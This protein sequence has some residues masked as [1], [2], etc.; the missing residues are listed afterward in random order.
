[1]KRTVETLYRIGLFASI[2]MIAGMDRS[3]LAQRPE[4]PK[5]EAPPKGVVLTGAAALALTG[6]FFYSPAPRP[7]EIWQPSAGDVA[8]L[9]KLLPGFM[10]SQK[11]LPR[12]YQPLHEYFRQYVGVVRNGKKLIAVSLIHSSILEAEERIQGKR[13]DFLK[14]HLAVSDGGAYV[15]Q[16]QFEPATGFFSDLRFNGDA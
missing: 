6:E 15:F 8:R 16:L 14:T 5:P 3:S 7:E 13:W 12:D 4:I 11:A 9:E 2:L 10:R 1:M